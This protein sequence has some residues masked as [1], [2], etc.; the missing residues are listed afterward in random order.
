LVIVLVFLALTM[1][2]PVVAPYDP[3]DQDLSNALSAPSLDHLFGADQYGRDVFSRVLY[4]T[5]DALLAIVVADG[6][7]SLRCAAPLLA[8]LA[9]KHMYQRI[10]V[11]I[12]ARDPG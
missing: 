5:R 3:T 6:I 7:A 2:A 1:L 10:V 12:G 11:L 4:G 8:A 9:A